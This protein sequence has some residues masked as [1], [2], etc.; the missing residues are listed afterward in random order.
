[1]QDKGKED[2]ISPLSSRR[3][4]GLT[5]S[6]IVSKTMQG[7]PKGTSRSTMD[8]QVGFRAKAVPMAT[9]D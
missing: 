2:D 5:S 7:G 4:N 9:I 1:M 3:K 6:C 8:E